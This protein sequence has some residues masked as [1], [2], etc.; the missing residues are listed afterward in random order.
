MPNRTAHFLTSALMSAMMV[1]AP[2]AAQAGGLSHKGTIGGM[3]RVPAT[4]GP[5]SR[6]TRPSIENIYK[7][8]TITNNLNV[9]KRTSIDKTINVYKPVTV[10]KMVDVTTN[11][12]NSKNITINK[13]VSITTN[14]DNS[15][16]IDITK[17]IDNSKTIDNSKNISINKSIVI[18]KG[19]DNISVS[20][21]AEASASANAA[22][23][24]GAGA[25]A[26]VIGGGGWAPEA[27]QPYM[28]GDIGSISV[29]AAPVHAQC[30]I[31]EATVVKAIH[32]VCI[33]A[34]GHEFPASHMLADTWISASYEGE[35]A[36]CIPGAHLKIV[37]S[38]VVQSNEGLAAGHKGEVLECGP[39]EA[40][41]HYKNG[42][43]KCAPAVPVPDCTER[44]N[45]R[46]YGSADMFF[47]YRAKVCLETDEEYSDNQSSDMRPKD[48][49]PI[50]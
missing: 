31:Q 12:D 4:C 36:R 25:G 32:A 3:S 40:L 11:V 39:H 15:K 43:L 49:N 28:G 26:V 30:T 33:A 29:E 27:P 8:A 44:T 5:V 46:K 10:N 19:G 47:S 6:P 45:L 34:G 9:Y 1:V 50:R 2:L 48:G 37:I 38:K 17:K 20:A 23:I 35:V 14:I 13:P 42:M 16:T 24:A 22:A 7:P 21:S 41:R 18:N